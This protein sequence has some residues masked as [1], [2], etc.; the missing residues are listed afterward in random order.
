MKWSECRAKLFV[1]KAAP[2]AEM[3]LSLV[4]SSENKLKSSKRLKIDET[5]ASSVVSLKY[6]ALREL[7][8]AIT[9]MNGSK[10]YNHDCLGAFLKE[11]LK[12]P[13][14]AEEFDRFRIIRNAA[15]YQGKD[16]KPDDAKILSAEMGNL[17]DALK[18][19]YV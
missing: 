10:V 2:D 6:D 13:D 14:L 7:L 18:A 12:R 5:T 15:N 17:I 11:V 9:I 16:I 19:E 3:F 1:R 4:E 8:E